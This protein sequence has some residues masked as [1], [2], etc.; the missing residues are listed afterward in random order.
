MGDKED[1]QFLLEAMSSEEVVAQHS[2][3]LV[4][5]IRDALD[6]KGIDIV[7]LQEV[8]ADVQAHL[9]ELCRQKGWQ[10][11]F[12]LGNEDPK[13]CAA[14]TGII[15]K[16]ALDEQMQVE[17]Q[18]NKKVRHFAAARKGT[19]WMVSCHVPLSNQTTEEAKQDVGARL[20]QEMSQRFLHSGCAL[21]VG[22]DWNADVNGV[23]NRV[24]A[25]LPYGCSQVSVHTDATTC[26]G[27]AFPV[28]GIVCLQ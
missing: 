8:G 6:A 12:G 26:H 13:K 28:D 18:E 17:F 14:M 11:L 2:R 21:I 3:H 22:G 1:R 16:T 15:S 23:K 27:A 19:A 25:S 5:T 9:T 10:A 4:D 7:L 24:A 20:V